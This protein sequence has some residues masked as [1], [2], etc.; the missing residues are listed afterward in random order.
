MR[1]G[2]FTC[3][4]M[5]A[6]A[7]NSVFNRMAVNGGYIDPSSFATLRTLSGALFLS[8]WVLLRRQPI[9]LLSKDRI[10]GGLS[11]SAYM[12]GFS[13]AYTILDAG[14]GALIL[15][16]TVQVSMFTWASVFG[17]RPS[18]LQLIGASVAFGGLLVALWP[19]NGGPEN[20]L[21]G[22]ALMVIAGLGWAAYSLAGRS[23]KDPLLSTAAN[24]IISV[25][26]VLL[27]SMG[28]IH[29]LTFTGGALAVLAGSI[30]SGV[31][32]AL[33]YSIL[34]HLSAQTAAVVQLSVPIIAI[35]VGAIFL[36]EPADMGLL[37]ATILVLGGIA[38]SILSPKRP[39]ERTGDGVA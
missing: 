8:A 32:Y 38:I 27:F 22:A 30:T 14:L 36:H 33:W 19:Q 25:P 20:Y 4:I 26:I 12:L 5:I 37:L 11:L 1:L 3:L 9:T 39:T 35:A 2:L 7:A 23:S 10:V 21:Y 6:F 17:S 28:S 18:I 13:L 29:Q 24:F 16:G 31:G 34:A 15:F